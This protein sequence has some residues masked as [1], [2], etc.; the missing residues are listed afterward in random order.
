MQDPIT[1]TRVL[2]DKKDQKVYTLWGFPGMHP[3]MPKSIPRKGKQGRFR[4]S[5][6]VQNRV[7]GVEK[8][9]KEIEQGFAPWK[10][11]FSVHMM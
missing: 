9:T 7:R 5:F 3:P 4:V 11:E 2:Q 1:E 8:E 10:K 6:D